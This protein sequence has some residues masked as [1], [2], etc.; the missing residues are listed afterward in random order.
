MLLSQEKVEN[1]FFTASYISSMYVP[2]RN[3]MSIVWIL[4]TQS[5]FHIMM[6]ERR[7]PNTASKVKNDEYE[8]RAQHKGLQ[9]RSFARP[10]LFKSI[11]RC[12]G[13]PRAEL[14]FSLRLS[15]SSTLPPLFRWREKGISPS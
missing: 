10:C 2:N 12:D 5:I 15:V 13:T 9:V 1:Y 6:R 14:E 8:S 11:S 7:R 3:T 4:A